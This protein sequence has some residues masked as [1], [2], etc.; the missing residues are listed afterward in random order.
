[1]YY[2]DDRYLTFNHPT[3]SGQAAIQTGDQMKDPGYLKFKEQIK[4][5]L[6]DLTDEEKAMMT[7]EQLQDIEEEKNTIMLQ[8]PRILETIDSLNPYD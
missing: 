2:D 5:V 4:E 3:N 8:T 7:E 1:M 6:R